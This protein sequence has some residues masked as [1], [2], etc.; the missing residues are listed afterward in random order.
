MA[1]IGII[2]SFQLNQARIAKE[3]CEKKLI[4]A[5][6]C[7]GKCHLKKQLKK[8]AE[9]ERKANSEQETSIEKQMPFKQVV[10]PNCVIQDLNPVNHWDTYFYPTYITF[11][12]KVFHPPSVLA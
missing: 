10:I 1:R 12:T 2:A 11:L 9:A 7:Q 6:T 4:A 8:I 3:L 5:N